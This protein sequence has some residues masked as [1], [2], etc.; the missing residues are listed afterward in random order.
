MALSISSAVTGAFRENSYLLTCTQTRE[1]VFVDPGDD[2][3]ALLRL[4][5]DAGARPVGIWNTHAHLDHVFGVAAL[6]R[7]FPG[8]PF[9]LHDDDVPWLESL[10]VQASMFGMDAP[11]R[12]V[13][14]GAL[15]DG[16]VLRFGSVSGTVLACPGHTEGGVSLWFE[17]AKALFTGDTLFV[18]SVG[19][20]DLPGGAFEV[21]ERSILGLYALP[22][23]ATFYSGHG[24]P[25]ELG[26]EKRRNPFVRLEA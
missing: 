11:G 1:A 8:L 5:T 2:V 21:L 18:G 19:R 22:D 7:A 10:E 26:R 12:P 9:L 6:Q 25:G 24:P 16:Q 15:V 14:T 23:D 17:E 20:T 13:R 3:P 4:L